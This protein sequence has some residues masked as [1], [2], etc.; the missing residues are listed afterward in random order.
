MY[1]LAT[2]FDRSQSAISEVV[3]ELTMFLD[4]RW[5]FLLDT[6]ERNPVLRPERLAE[7]AAAIHDAGSPLSTIWCFIDCTIRIMCRPHR[8]QRQA[9]NGYKGRHALKYQSI[10]LPN[11]LIGALYGPVEGRRNDNHLLS[12]SGLIEWCYAHAFRPGA[13]YTTPIAERYFQAFGDPANG[14]N[15]VL[16][17]PYAGL[18]QRTEEEKKWNEAMAAV[19][20]EVEHGF[21]DVIRSWPFLNAWWVQ[22]VFSSPVG[23]YYRVAVLLSNALNCVRPNQTA[24]TLNCEPPTLEDYFI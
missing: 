16:M 20:I 10:K 11:G 6:D 2:K 15:P 21:A 18:G 3:N 24:Q 7:Y 19:R 13:D 17:S 5:K 9:Y 1:N 22:R 14:I 12:E 4:K 23:S 8:W